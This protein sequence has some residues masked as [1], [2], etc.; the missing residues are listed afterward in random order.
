MKNMGK[1]IK[2]QRLKWGYT[3]DEVVDRVNASKNIH[4]SK[5]TLSKL[6]NGLLKKTPRVLVDELA[7]IYN[8]DPVYLMGYHESDTVT[9]TYSAPG[10]EDVVLQAGGKPIIGATSL[11]ARLL[12]EATKVP[13]ENIPAAIEVLKSLQYG[14][15]NNAEV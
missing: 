4:T 7:H 13:I 2:E 10:K 12:Q 5:S 3:L 11:R 15:E 14:G 1:R 6:E 8:C 9:L